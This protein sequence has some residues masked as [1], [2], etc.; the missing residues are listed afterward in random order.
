[1]SGGGNA[2]KVNGSQQPR[3]DPQ[4]TLD[5]RGSAVKVFPAGEPVFPAESSCCCCTLHWGQRTSKDGGAQKSRSSSSRARGGVRQQHLQEPPAPH[6]H[7]LHL[8]QLRRGDGQVPPA[9]ALFRTA[10][11]QALAAL[12]EICT[13]LHG[14]QTWKIICKKKSLWR[15]ILSDWI[16]SPN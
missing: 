6:L 3:F 10:L 16:K 9:P 7:A 1:M 15:H 11:S 13:L 2:P 12:A 8:C 14:K 4:P 5:I